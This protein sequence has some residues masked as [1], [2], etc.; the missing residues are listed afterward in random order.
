MNPSGDFGRYYCFDHGEDFEQDDRKEAA[1]H[2]VNKHGMTNDQALAKLDE[3]DE[4]YDEMDDYD[5]GLVK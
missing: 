2:L 3:I 4:V 1:K 5:E